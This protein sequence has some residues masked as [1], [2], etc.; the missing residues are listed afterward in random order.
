MDHNCTCWH[1]MDSA[2][3]DGTVIELKNTY[4]LAPWYG[5][6]KWTEH[7]WEDAIQSGR[8]ISD[9]D[10]INWR[11]Y[12]GEIESY[13]DPTSGAQETT[14]YWNEQAQRRTWTKVFANNVEL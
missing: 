13:Q 9:D 12:S 14:H 4:G 6:F 11:R 3:R 1:E 2:P 5:L 8:T 10:Y 7:G